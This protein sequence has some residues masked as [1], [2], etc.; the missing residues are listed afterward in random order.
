MNTIKSK[1]FC[2]IR[3]HTIPRC[4]IS[5][6]IF[7]INIIIRKNKIFRNKSKTSKQSF[8]VHK[9]SNKFNQNYNRNSQVDREVYKIAKSL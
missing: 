4:L 6:K 3:I 8:K 2:L 1:G 9:N 5:H 7:I